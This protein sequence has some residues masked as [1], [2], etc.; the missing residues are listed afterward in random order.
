LTRLGARL[1]CPIYAQG[2]LVAF[3]LLG[4]Q[5]REEAYG[6][7]DYDLLRGI[8]HHVGA[9][10]AH[11]GLAEERQAAAELEALHRFSVFCL[12]DRL[13]LVA[14]NAEQHGRDPA[15]QESAMRTVADT[16]QKM[17]RLM[18]KLSLKSLQPIVAQDSELVEMFALAEEVVAPLTG[19]EMVRLQVIGGPV[20]PIRAVREQIHQV[21]LNVV[22]NA[23]QAIS[24]SGHIV[25][26]LEQSDCSVIIRVKDTGSGI[27]SSMLDT[28]FRPF[29]SNRPGGLGVGLY[30]CK[31]IVETHGG[32]IQIR[33]E[34]GKGTLVQ[35]EFPL[36]GA[37]GT[38]PVIVHTAMSS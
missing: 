18:S 3:I 37:S 23:R 13:S 16:A 30:Q 25:I 17:T 35:I 31:R 19:E 2:R 38:S 15:F 32:T 7:D 26:S 27:P 4:K 21:L 28:L 29:Q 20:Q 24:Q 8:C 14:Q 9:L 34:Q 12:H 11:A 10:L 5:F 6:T 22:L 33:S 1:C 36:P